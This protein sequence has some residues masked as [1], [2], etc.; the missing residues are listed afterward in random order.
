MGKF[1]NLLNKILS[2]G[3]YIKKIYRN[4]ITGKFVNEEYVKENPN[5][6]TTEVRE[7]KKKKKRLI[8][9]I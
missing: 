5:T 3:T 9:I 2:S 8:L 4:S 7:I 6:T 1:K